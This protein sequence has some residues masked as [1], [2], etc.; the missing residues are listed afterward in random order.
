MKKSV[1]VS[2]NIHLVVETQMGEFSSIKQTLMDLETSFVSVKNQYEDE[3]S[4]LKRKLEGKST[5]PTPDKG[6]K[7]KVDEPFPK[8]N[9]SFPS[10]AQH[11]LNKESNGTHTTYP[12]LKE[13]MDEPTEEKSETRRGNDWVVVYN[14]QVKTN[15]NTNLL[16]SLEHASVVCCVR[17]SKD[18]NYLATGSNRMTQLYSVET[19]QKVRT[20]GDKK[21]LEDSYVRS[22]CFSPDGSLLCA[23]AEDKVVRVWDVNSGA[24]K[25]SFTGHELDIYSLD[26]SWDSKIVVSGSG[27]GKAKI[28]DMGAGKCLFTLGSEE[29][30]P[31]EGVTSVSLSPDGKVVAA[32]SLDCTVRLWD[33]TNGQLIG[34]LKGHDD[35]VYSVAFSP[36]GKTLASGSLDKTLKLWDMTKYQANR[37]LSTLVG[38]RDYVLS[39]AFTPDGKW[40]I[41]GSKDRAVQFWDP[42]TS[43]LHLMLQGHK[44][45]VISVAPNPKQNIFATG[46][47]DCRARIWKYDNLNI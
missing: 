17:F 19:G 39:V 3:I 37:C 31:K 46:S 33:T 45:S 30:G 42:K 44:N 10:L 9:F 43:V 22:V 20:Y 36:D 8:Q 34:T 29:V 47:G 41:S 12:P 25:H 5:S 24:L 4:R 14:P 11:S 27:D 7:T 6:K 15:V 13:I 40:L 18:G 1:S 28:W 32:G 16:H 2:H 38:H 26:Y 23:G 35:S 21:G